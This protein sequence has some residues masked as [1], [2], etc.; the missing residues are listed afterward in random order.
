MHM[1][2]P[3]TLRVHHKYGIVALIFVSCAS[4]FRPGAS[5][6]QALEG[7]ARSAAVGGASTAL[8]GGRWLDANAAV[9]A[10]R[11]ARS[12]SFFASESYGLSE[13]RLAQAQ[14]TETLPFAALSLGVSSFGFEDYR[15]TGFALAAAREFSL[16]STR[17]AAFGASLRYS[18]VAISGYGSASATGLT[19]AGL[20]AVS[21]ILDLG[22]QAT[23]INAPSLGDNDDMPRT[24]TAGLYYRPEDRVGVLIDVVKEARFEPAVRGG[25]ELRLADPLTVRSGF[26][27]NPSRFALGIGVAVGFISIDFAV[28]RHRLLGWTPAASLNLDW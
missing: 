16:G 12:I 17:R 21:P 14:Y 5:H 23:N 28:E 9:G 22:F 3:K 15:L 1:P 27:T 25:L 7:G 26:G 13:L 24:L 10:T 20:I 6:G 4:G 19:V 8:R 18:Q 11:E 2:H